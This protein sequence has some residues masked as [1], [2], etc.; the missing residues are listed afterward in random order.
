MMYHYQA[1]QGVKT[2]ILSDEY[3]VTSFMHV[4]DFNASALLKQF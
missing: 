4:P 3:D 2:G 1:N